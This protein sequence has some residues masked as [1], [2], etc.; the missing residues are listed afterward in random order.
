L[1]EPESIGEAYATIAGNYYELVNY[2]KSREFT[3]KCL[4]VS[5]HLPI[6][7]A[8]ALDIEGLNLFRQSQP[9]KATETILQAVD[10]YKAFALKSKII[11]SYI[12]VGWICDEKERYMDAIDYY[13]NAIELADETRDLVKKMDLL[14]SY[15]SDLQR[16]EKYKEALDPALKCLAIAEDLDR[17]D[18][19]APLVDLYCPKGRRLGIARKIGAI[20]NNLDD[21]D[22]SLEYMLR[23]VPVNRTVFSLEDEINIFFD[24]S[25]CCKCLKRYD[26]SMAYVE[27]ELELAEQLPEEFNRLDKLSIICMHAGQ[28][29]REVKNLESA[30]DFIQKSL[31]YC[32]QYVSLKE[33]R[34]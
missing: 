18:P 26:E 14:A 10:T 13:Q 23:I 34:K 8:E 28:V 33:S 6:V 17:L 31:E 1:R 19:D 7:R 30:K 21:Y 15:A 5:E 27:K 16:L 24:I 22:K 25:F 20:Y 4:D 3:Q 32:E 12:Y 2:E 9:E 11:Q 29:Q